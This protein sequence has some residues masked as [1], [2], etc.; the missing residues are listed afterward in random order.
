M[1]DPADRGR[2]NQ[3]NNYPA[4]ITVELRRLNIYDKRNAFLMN[5]GVTMD[6]K[7]SHQSDEYSSLIDP[8]FE[9]KSFHA[10]TVDSTALDLAKRSSRARVR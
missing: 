7:L 6:I 3:G 4:S 10:F 5:A 2:S 8:D 1:I 9:L